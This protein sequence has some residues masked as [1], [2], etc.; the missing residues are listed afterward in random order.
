MDYH[1]EVLENTG[2]IRTKGK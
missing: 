2:I 1:Q